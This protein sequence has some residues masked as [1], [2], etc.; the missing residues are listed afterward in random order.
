MKAVPVIAIDGPSGVGKGTVARA[1]ARRLGWH[2]LDS[3]A[4]YRILALAAEK[5]GVRLQD[6]A[7]VAALAPRL[8]IKFEVQGTDNERIIVGGKDL[9]SA[10]RDERA[11]QVA[12]IIAVAPQVR[13]ALLQR[14]REFRR[15]PGLVADGRDMG[16]VVFPDAGLKIFLD[17]TPE[18]RA[19]RR[20]KQLSETGINAK[21]SNLCAEIRERDVRDRNRPHS[22]LKAAPDAVVIDTTELPVEGVLSRVKE[23]IVARGYAT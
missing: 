15:P 3:G 8:D 13:A 7:G 19:Q 1:T 10:V 14:Q 2:F 9:T 21:L 4:L 20:F 22:P 12:S 5:A 17:A 23:L 16:T 18:E 6:Y 11:G